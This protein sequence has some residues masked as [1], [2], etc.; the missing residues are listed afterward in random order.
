M[1][2]KDR[3]RKKTKVTKRCSECA[4]AV[5]DETWGEYK[6]KVHQHRIRKPDD[7]TDCQEYKKAN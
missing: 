2:T 4:N 5:L 3:R 6:C 1:D 7:H